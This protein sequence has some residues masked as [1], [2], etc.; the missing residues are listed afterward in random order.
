MKEKL[1]ASDMFKGK[2]SLYP[3]SVPV[4]FQGEYVKLSNNKKWKKTTN[5]APVIWADWVSKIN[6][7]NG[8]TVN[9]VLVVTS[10]SLLLINP[11]N[12]QIKYKIPFAEIHRISVSPFCDQLVMFHVKKNIEQKSLS[13]G[14]F[15]FRTSHTIEL[16]T[17]IVV[18]MKPPCV[19]N[20]QI[21]PRIKAEF[22]KSQV[23]LNFSSSLTE[24]ATPC[25]RRRGK[26]TFNIAVYDSNMQH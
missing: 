15:L 7:K 23:D 24:N 10:D 18:S 16:V 12:V 5:N 14:D 13:K 26:N 2:K 4:P 8:K 3:E 21:T 25:V 22:R 19:V 9:R 17:K 6:R 1:K 20:L 11:K